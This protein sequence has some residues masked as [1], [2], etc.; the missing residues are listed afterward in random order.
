MFKRI[1]RNFDVSVVI[2]NYNGEN[3]LPD[4]LPYVIKAK[5][6]PANR[7]REIIVVDDDSQDKSIEV[8]KRFPG[9]KVIKHRINRGFSSSVNTGARSSKGKII[10]LLN[11]DVKPSYDFLMSVL[12]HFSS[13]NVFAVSLHE[14]GYGW[15]NGRFKDGFI[16]HSPGKQDEEVQETFWVN[17]GSGVFRRD[18]WMDLN[19]MDERI[20]SPFYWEDLDLSYRAQKR[21]FTLLWDP[22]S[23]VTHKHESTLSR[24]PNRYVVRIQER[25]Q[26]L[27][28]WKNLTSVALFRKHVIGLTSRVLRHPG[29]V[30]VVFSALSKLGTV[31]KARKKELKEA[32]ISDETIFARFS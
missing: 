9:V 12:P 31:L 14:E 13:P 27:F 32:K 22:K 17:G 6:N 20:F 25:N 4:C 29:Y 19:G 15:A 23:M 21:G 2:P 8:L 26:L 5:D 18:Y 3:L 11:T 7:I 10:V 28:I 24:L 30:F 1:E 16:V